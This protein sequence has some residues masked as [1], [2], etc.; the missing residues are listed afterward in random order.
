MSERLV[1][2]GDLSIDSRLAFVSQ[3]TAAVAAADATGTGAEVDCSAVDV[4][5]P[6]DDTVIG[7]LV[8]L[9]RAAQRYGARIMLI[10]APKPMRA[11]LEA[12]GVAH[13]FDFR[14]ETSR[15]PRATP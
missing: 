10:S 7:M 6:V 4:F 9:A 3:A 1:L 13:F 15:L 11:Q 8:T 14:R 12:A 2:R 5:G